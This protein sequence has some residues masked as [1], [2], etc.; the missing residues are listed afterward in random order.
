MNVCQSKLYQ[1]NCTYDIWIS[2]IIGYNS[3]CMCWVG[4]WGCVI[5]RCPVLFV[6]TWGTEGMGLKPEYTSQARTHTWAGLMTC[7][8]LIWSLYRS[9]LWGENYGTK[10]R[11]S[12][13]GVCCRPDLPSFCPTVASYTQHLSV[14]L[15]APPPDLDIGVPRFA[16]LKV[17]LNLGLLN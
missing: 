17:R 11:S 12:V 10:D 13:L 7:R 14:T 4:G 5:D 16:G 8:L 6:Y 15:L 3:K 1:R 2:R 9:A